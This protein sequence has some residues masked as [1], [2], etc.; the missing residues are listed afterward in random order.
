MT[1]TVHCA[2]Q[3]T[4]IGERENILIPEV[5]SLVGMESLWKPLAVILW[6]RDTK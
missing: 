4:T 5:S 3:G 6:L 2:N 1:L